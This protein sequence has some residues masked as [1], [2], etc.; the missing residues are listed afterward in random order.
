MSK[1]AD[2]AREVE[3]LKHELETI[4]TRGDA[5]VVS[6]LR[7]ALSEYS[8]GWIDNYIRQFP[9]MLPAEV[10]RLQANDRI[11]QF[12]TRI[13]AVIANIP[14]KIQELTADQR[15]LPHRRSRD[16]L[17]DVA[18]PYHED[19]FEKAVLGAI[20][21]IG[22]ILEGF[23][24]WPAVGG[25]ERYVMSGKRLVYTG[26]IGLKLE[27]IPAYSGYENLV[28]K[29]REVQNRLLSKQRELE[30]AKAQEL[31]DSD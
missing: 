24:F 22:E 16:G 8:A 15:R 28:L 12:K 17:W 20:N 2:L 7:P 4:G 29:S 19:D 18:G 25:W 21:D 31:F 6:S 5:I 1:S 26:Q 14:A 11:R 10:N 27:K 9:T 13:A 3:A 23:G 30:V